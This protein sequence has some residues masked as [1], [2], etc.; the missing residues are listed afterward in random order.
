M[1][2]HIPSAI[3][4]RSDLHVEVNRLPMNQGTTTTSVAMVGR[5]IGRVVSGP[6]VAVTEI[7]LVVTDEHGGM[8]LSWAE[9]DELRASLGK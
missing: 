9:L 2:P 8:A 1:Q 6:T 3:S 7:G 4:K 5:R